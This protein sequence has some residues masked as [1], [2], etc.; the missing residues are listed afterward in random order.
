MDQ[1][2]IEANVCDRCQARENA[3]ER[4]TIGFAL[5]KVEKVARILLTNHRA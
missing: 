5:R 1:S 2:E 3:C 4:G